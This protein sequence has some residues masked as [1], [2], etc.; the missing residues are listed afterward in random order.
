MATR[1]AVEWTR[2]SLRIAVAERRGRAWTLK[3]V[4]SEP[5]VEGPTMAPVL[6][7]AW[8]ALKP[9]PQEV[10]SVLPREQV[11][12][13]IVKFPTLQDAELHQMVELYARGQLPYPRE[14]AVVAHQVV[15]RAEGFSTV[16]IVACQRDVVDRHLA[17]LREAGIPPQLVTVSSWG[18]WAWWR[19]A[20]KD[21]PPDPLLIVHLD[22]ARTDLLVV[23]DETILLSRSV[24]QGV[25][26]WG[27]ASE[28]I[29]L[30]ATEIDRSL[31]ALRRELPGVDVRGVL[32]TG[33]G[34]LETW[35]GALAERV[36]IPVAAQ[37]PRAALGLQAAGVT[38]ATS[39]AVVLGAAQAPGGVLLDLSPPEVRTRVRQRRQSQDLTLVGGLALAAGLLGAAVLGVQVVR[40]QE[41]AARLAQVVS[42]VAPTAKTI[43][44][45]ARAVQVASGVLAQR[46]QLAAILSGVFRAAPA[47][48]GLEAVT[49]EQTRQEIVVRGSAPNTQDV[50][51]FVGQLEQLEGIAGARLKYSTRRRTP[52]GERTD[53]EI[54]MQQR[55]VS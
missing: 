40:Q 44:D 5:A 12:T 34:A 43:R 2:A 21:A 49:A 26:D 23:T 28:T 24:G 41:R 3:Y 42:E 17:L 47:G 19:Q 54:V 14:Q 39:P 30:L 4:R 36:G 51:T 25:S 8:R 52:T 46:R 16:G 7:Q 55:D 35:R 31:A 6:G 11:I 15:R 33:I 37:D 27:A 20:R 18:V 48:I 32:L 10:V 53:F 38:P 50:L 1:F 13:R 22:D 9:A 29:D 45:Q